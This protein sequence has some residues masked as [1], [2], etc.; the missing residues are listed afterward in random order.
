MEL[1][2]EKKSLFLLA[3][4]ENTNKRNG[5]KIKSSHKKDH[6]IFHIKIP[7][8]CLTRTYSYTTIHYTPSN[9]WVHTT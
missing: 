5:T 9:I 4:S 2:G 6:N 8:S 7:Q 3:S 1:S